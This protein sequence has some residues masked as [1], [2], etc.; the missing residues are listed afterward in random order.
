MYF[1]ELA[2]HD[3]SYVETVRAK[4]GLKNVKKGL[5]STFDSYFCIR[6][7]FIQE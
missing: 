5:P 2:G 3:A 7:T 1:E 6:K 4:K